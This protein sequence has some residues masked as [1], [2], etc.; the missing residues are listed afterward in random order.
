MAE[1]WAEEMKKYDEKKRKNEG[2]FFEDTA[3]FLP[4]NAQAADSA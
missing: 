2:G 4:H 1:N 3:K